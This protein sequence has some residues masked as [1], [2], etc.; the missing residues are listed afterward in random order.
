MKRDQITGAIF[1]LL[2]AFL[3]GTTGSTQ[4]LAPSTATPLSIASL[5]MIIGGLGLLTYAIINN[6]FKEKIIWPKK[7]LMCAAI[8]IAA[9]Q[10]LFFA[11]VSKTGIAFGTVL[12]IGSSPVFIGILQ[13]FKGVKLSLQWII[14]SIVAV[15]GCVLLFSGQSSM[16]INILGSLFALGAGFTYALYVQTSKELFTTCPR[17]A[18][19]GVLFFISG[20]ILLPLL[21]T[22]NISWVLTSQGLLV[23]MHLGLIATALAYTLFG[24]GLVRVSSATAVTLTLGEPLTAALL[25]VFFF[26]ETLT[27]I[28]TIGLV[29][30]FVGLLV[31][32]IP[33]KNKEKPTLNKDKV[34]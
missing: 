10:P 22:Q 25:G 29:L 11:G 8:S 27:L 7:R 14:S 24:I 12:A 1:I 33:F 15:L 17:T 19:N 21:L 13:S 20:L 9:F 23:S 26:K 4:G 28:S 32:A 2:A 3:W 6:S 5:R 30:V 31:S 16:S 34:G 18:V